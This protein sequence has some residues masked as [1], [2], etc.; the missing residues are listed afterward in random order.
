MLQHG[1]PLVE[2]AELVAEGEPELQPGLAVGGAV[3][4]VGEAGG[5]GN[6]GHGQVAR[7]AG[8]EGELAEGGEWE[9]RQHEVLQLAGQPEEGRRVPAAGEQGRARGGCTAAGRRW[10]VSASSV[11]LT[12]AYK[13]FRQI[14]LEEDY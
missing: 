12:K 7:R 4:M 6:P 3:D 1:G 14:V 2:H 5:G 11:N 13:M 8:G 9:D 10:T